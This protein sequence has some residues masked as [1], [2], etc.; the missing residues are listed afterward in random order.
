MFCNKCGKQIEDGSKFCQYCGGVQE[1]PMGVNK[2]YSPTSYAQTAILGGMSVI[3]IVISAIY[4]ILLLWWTSLFF[5]EIKDVWI[6]FKHLENDAKF[7]GMLLYITPYVLLLCLVIV[8]IQGIRMHQYHVSIGVIISIIGI[9]TKMGA[10]IFDEVSYK[11]YQIIITRVFS[12]YGSIGL[13]TIVL[14]IIISVLVYAKMN[15]NN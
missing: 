8:G 1:T 15:S 14:G 7:I 9:V 2:N 13:S 4:I 11:T 6:T 10:F 5:K 12:V 3:D